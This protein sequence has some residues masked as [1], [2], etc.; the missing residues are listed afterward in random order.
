MIV[1]DNPSLKQLVYENLRERIIHGELKPGAWLREADLSKEMNISRAPIREA[2]SM[3]ERDRFTIVLPRRGAIVAEVTKDDI[4]YVWEMRALLEPYAAKV[5]VANI[6]EEKLLEVRD[7]LEQVGQDYSN[8]ELYLKSDL[9]THRLFSDYLTNQY[10]KT[11]VDNITAHSLRLRWGAEY[12][13]TEVN[14]KMIEKINT[15]HV[16]ILDALIERDAEK[17][18]TLVSKHIENARRRLMASV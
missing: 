2:L 13:S 5:S 8:R 3:L 11:S 4:R 17:T 1:G 6:P 7:L 14:A 12:N 16:R 15:E 18:Y 9:E 10:L